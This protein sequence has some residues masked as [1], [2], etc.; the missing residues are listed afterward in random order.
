VVARLASPGLEKDPAK[1]PDE[2]EQTEENHDGHRA[3]EKR[4]SPTGKDED[5]NQEEDQP[6]DFL[7]WICGTSRHDW[8][9][10]D[11]CP[12]NPWRPFFVQRNKDG[13]SFTLLPHGS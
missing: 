1:E 3:L 10:E 13:R 7:A 11:A 8:E 9:A 4:R 12:E 6:Q 2:G 5:R